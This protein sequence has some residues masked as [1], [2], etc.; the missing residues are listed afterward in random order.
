[1][2]ADYC[3]GFEWS[4][5]ATNKAWLRLGLFGGGFGIDL[6]NGAVSSAP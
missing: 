2:C 4:V 3:T 6:D 1:M 5:W